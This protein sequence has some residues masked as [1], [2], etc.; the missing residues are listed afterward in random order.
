MTQDPGKASGL[1]SK[2]GAAEGGCV[3][4]GAGVGAAI[5]NIGIG[6]AL[7]LALAIVIGAALSRKGGPSGD[8]AK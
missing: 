1:A 3:A 5:G 7:G 6:V 8:V 4:F 2:V